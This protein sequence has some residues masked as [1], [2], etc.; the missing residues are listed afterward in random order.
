MAWGPAY[1]GEGHA[2]RVWRADDRG[3]SGRASPVECIRAHALRALDGE[4]RSEG[5]SEGEWTGLADDSELG[6]TVKRGVRPTT[7]PGWP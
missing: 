7:P 6:G 1:T 5:W 4:D 2:G 3:A